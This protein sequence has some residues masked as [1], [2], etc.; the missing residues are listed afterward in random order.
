MIQFPKLMLIPIN[1]EVFNHAGIIYNVAGSVAALILMLLPFLKEFKL[2]IFFLGAIIAFLFVLP[3][4]PLF[5]IGKDL[6]SSRYLYISAFGPALIGAQL[7]ALIKDRIKFTAVALVW[8]ILWSFVTCQNITP[9]KEAGKISLNVLN[10]I[11]ITIPN[12]R[13]GSSIM[14]MDLPDNFKGAPVWRNGLA[15]ALSLDYK[16]PPEIEGNKKLLP[17]KV[18]KD[19]ANLSQ[20][21]YLLEWDNSSDKIID[22]TDLLRNRLAIRE[23]LRLTAQGKLPPILIRGVYP[24][25]RAAS[26]LEPVRGQDHVFKII[27][28]DPYFLSSQVGIN[29]LLVESV[30]VTMKLSPFGMIREADLYWRTKSDFSYR[31]WRKAKFIP[32]ADGMMHVYTLEVSKLPAWV[33]SDTIVEIRLDPADGPGLIEVKEIA[34]IP[35]GK[36]Q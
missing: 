15:E 21:N 32:V 8:I 2:R 7:V 10:Q 28:A 18:L 5:D 25:L 17:V 14:I 33:L 22:R 19:E 27:G 20:L 3:A 24:H 30:N 12:L 26:D 1:Q 4:F 31:E 11:K 36:E 23:D 29:P 34:I 35:I 6:E 16:I 13:Q 9:W